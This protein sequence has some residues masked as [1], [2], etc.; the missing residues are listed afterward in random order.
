VFTIGEFSKVTG[1]TVKTLRFY[2]AAGADV[3]RRAV[4]VSVLRCFE[5]EAARVISF[6]RS[7]EFPV[8]EIRELLRGSEADL[9]TA[10]ERQRKLIEERMKKLRKIAQ[11]LTSFWLPKRSSRC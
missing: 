7:L 3:R 11:S 8:A 2:H 6:L 9:T 1:L 5:I 4:G 10:L